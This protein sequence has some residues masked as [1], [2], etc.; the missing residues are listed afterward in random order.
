A[1]GFLNN[2]PAA[3]TI[4]QSGLQVPT[5]KTLSI[6]GGDISFNGDPILG[7]LSAPSGT[8]QMTSVGS[9]GE[10]VPT[11][12]G[13][14]PDV[15]VESFAQLG[16]ITVAHGASLSVVGSNSNID[17]GGSIVLRGDHIIFTDGSGISARGNPGGMVSMKGDSVL[18]G[19]TVVNVGTRGSVDHPGV[20]VDIEARQDFTMTDGEIAVSGFG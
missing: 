7:F 2:T 5:G 13:S 15:T 1:F 3:I 20:A 10:A 11:L 18:L 19:N 4:Q 8:I 14:T 16:T 17:P 6:V 9:A 12:S